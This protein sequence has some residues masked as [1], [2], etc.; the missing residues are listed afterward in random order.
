MRFLKLTVLATLLAPSLAAQ[1]GYRP[2]RHGFWFG[3]GLGVGAGGLHCGI[4]E[5]GGGQGTSG[6]LRAGTTVNPRLL[7]GVEGSGWQKNGEE[8]KR[9]ILAL[10]GGI[11]WYPRSDAG[12]F[13]RGGVGISGWRAAAEQEAVVSRALALTVGAGYEARVA[14][15]LSVVPFVNVLGSSGGALWLEHRDEGSYERNRLPARGHTVLIQLGIGFT[16]H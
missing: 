8:G 12:H 10:T 16:R 13:I 3:A 9:R 6:Y 5:S 14:P 7:V 11:W 15:Y 4:C 2:V 1:S